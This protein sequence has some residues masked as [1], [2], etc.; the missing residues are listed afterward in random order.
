MINQYSKT[1]FSF[2][3]ACFSKCLTLVRHGQSIA[4]AGL[5]IHCTYSQYPI[6]ELGRKQAFDFANSIKDPP[7]IIYASSFLRTQQTSIP[8]RKK[9]P[10]VPFRIDARLRAFTYLDK[11]YYGPLRY[12]RKDHIKGYWDKQDPYFYDGKETES[13]HDFYQRAISFLDSLK[14]RKENNIIAFTHSMFVRFTEVYLSHPNDSIE[15][16]MKNYSQY[17]QWRKVKNG[18][19][20]TFVIN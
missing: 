19:A 8:L 13:F 17:R 1:P 2:G 11:P 9:F 7:D 16:F 10:F 15:L 6:T 4:N 14:E 20:V 18:E 3:I 5:P 12:S